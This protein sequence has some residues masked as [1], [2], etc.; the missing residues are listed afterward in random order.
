MN[1]NHVDLHVSDVDAARQFFERHFGLR[2]VY[3]RAGQIALLHDEA[4]LELGVS[5]LRHS[6]PS[7]YPADFHV[8]FVLDGAAGVREAYE[9]LKADGVRIKIDLREGGPNLFFMCEGPDGIP[10]EVRAPL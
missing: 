5:N 2:C 10:V 4:G 8:G 9:R 7:P 6:P 3:Q 1:L